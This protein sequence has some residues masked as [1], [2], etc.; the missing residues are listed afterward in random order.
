MLILT[1]VTTDIFS[2][3][4]EPP[5]YYLNAQEIDFENVH[6]KPTSIDEMIL[7]KKTE[8]GAV[9]MTTKKNVKF[10]TLDDILRTKT[11]VIDSVSQV[12]YIVD[13]K[14]VIDKSKVKVDASYFID[15]EVKRL[16][17]LNYIS[18]EHRGLIIV[19]IQLLNEKPKPVIRI[20]G[21]EGLQTKK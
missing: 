15:V 16:E 8:R 5:L 12:V 6:V 14:L 4:S 18:E 13:D 19:E 17:K 20:R 9:Y 3:R 1:L 21:D 11:G 7:D 10:L 2:Q